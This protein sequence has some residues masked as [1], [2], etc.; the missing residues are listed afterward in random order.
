MSEK[1]DNVCTQLYSVFTWVLEHSD[2]G[3]CLKIRVTYFWKAKMCCAE[4][5]RKQI[6]LLKNGL[7]CLASL[8]CML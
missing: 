2:K 8:P 1:K 3:I 4:N 5:E 6:V 7:I